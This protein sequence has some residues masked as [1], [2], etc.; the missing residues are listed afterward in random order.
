MVRYVVTATL[1]RAADS[2]A[3]VGL[4]LLAVEPVTGLPHGARAGGLLA[5]ALTAPHLAGPWLARWLD[6]ASDGRYLLAASF[7]GFGASL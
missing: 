2:G 5:A 7:V 4:V 6:R 3:A 1:A